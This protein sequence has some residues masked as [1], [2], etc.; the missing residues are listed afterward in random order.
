MTMRANR[1]NNSEYFI[2]G[3]SVKFVQ[4]FFPSL[5]GLKNLNS[6]LTSDKH[7][8]NFASS[9]LLNDLPRPLPNKIENEKLL[10]RQAN[11][12]TCQG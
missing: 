1:T 10:A 3:L 2:D 11:N 8:S 6:S 4:L 9:G 5:S 12:Y 7:V